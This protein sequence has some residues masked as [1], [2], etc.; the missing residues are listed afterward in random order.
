MEWFPDGRA[1][2]RRFLAGDFFLKVGEPRVYAHHETTL[3]E[4]FYWSTSPDGA[5]YWEDVIRRI[6]NGG[7]EVP[8]EARDKLLLY[9]LLED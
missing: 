7:T 6:I 3:G 8:E 2:L 4:A 5:A 1:K 9:L